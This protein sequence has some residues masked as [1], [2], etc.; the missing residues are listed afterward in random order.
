LKGRYPFI[1]AQLLNRLFYYHVFMSLVYYLYVTFNPSDSKNYYASTFLTDDWFSLYGTS[2]TFIKF[3]VYPFTRYLAFSYEAAM[4]LFAW[5]G[6]LGFVYF[7]VF[8]REN[9][10]FRHTFFGYDLLTIIFFLP[11]LHFWSGSVGKGSVIFL[12]IG[13][14]FFGLSKIRTRFVA[15]A[16][17]GLLIYHIRP[18]I[19]FVV[20]LSSAV[21]FMFSSRG[22]SMT[23]RIVFLLGATVAFFFI[24]RD[25]L[26]LVGI[27]EEGMVSQGLDLT[28]RATEL[29]KATSGVDITNY[30][31]PLQVF[32]FLYRPLFFDAPGA[33]GLFVSVENVFYLVLTA[34]M[35][36]RI[37]GWRFLLGGT[38]LTKSAFLSF[39]TVSIAL[40]QVAGNL[41]LAIRQ[42]SQVM[43]LFMFVIISFLDEQKMI[44]WRRQMMSQKR[45]KTLSRSPE[46][47]QSNGKDLR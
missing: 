38:V 33:L 27:D 28:H 44:A 2:T 24:Y 21:A 9:I 43:I 34:M 30:S 23:W 39:L 5:F 18:H 46:A 7:Y 6:Y 1:D 40:A 15:L 22:V 45:R 41:G 37:K 8:F 36:G 12:G 42:K 19:M 14:F 13:L 20:L 11:N 16:I 17:A 31:L 47:T 35:F 32:T 29:S 25:V 26:T 10:K 3:L 4:A